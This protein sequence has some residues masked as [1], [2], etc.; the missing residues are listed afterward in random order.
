MELFLFYETIGEYSNME[1]EAKPKANKQGVHDTN[2]ID[3]VIK[4]MIQERKGVDRA[5]EIFNSI[6]V[7]VSGSLD[8]KEFTEA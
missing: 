3:R 2:D 7:D 8:L 5:V 1:R 6:D 4:D